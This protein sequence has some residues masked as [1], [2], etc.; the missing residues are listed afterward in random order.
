LSNKDIEINKLRSLKHTI[1]KLTKTT[2]RTINII[3]FVQQYIKNL[4]IKTWKQNCDQN[5]RYKSRLC[6]M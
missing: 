6:R 1:L 5:T 4:H 2:I 3:L